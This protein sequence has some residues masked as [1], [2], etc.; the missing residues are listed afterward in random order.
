MSNSAETNFFLRKY[1][2]KARI[3]NMCLTFAT[4]KFK[5]LKRPRQKQ[6]TEIKLDQETE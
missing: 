6:I 1:Q 3:I 5:P 4:A 2:A